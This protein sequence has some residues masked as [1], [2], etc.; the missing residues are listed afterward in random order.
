M[1]MP[2]AA[3]QYS[4]DPS[5]PM[6]MMLS[7]CLF[8]LDKPTAAKLMIRRTGNG[9]YEI[10]GRK[11]TLRWSGKLDSTELFVREDQVEGASE[12][13]VVAYLA[14][15]AHVAASLSGCGKGLSAI[16]R[17]P[18]ER[19]LTFR[20]T[21]TAESTAK[22][23]D[24]GSHIERVSSMRLACEQAKIRDTA[25]AAYELARPHSWTLGHG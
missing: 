17:I 12:L 19:R 6:D 3:C 20:E 15:A 9:K 8:S 2:V 4:G 21:A 25:A 16:G 14:Q 5:D 1:P 7:W 11:V 23:D 13:S 18:Q 10:D 24:P 22:L